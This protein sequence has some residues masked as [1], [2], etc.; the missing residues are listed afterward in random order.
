M[1]QKCDGPPYYSFAGKNRTHTFKPCV[2][3]SLGPKLFPSPF[4]TTLDLHN[5]MNIVNGLVIFHVLHLSDALL[6]GL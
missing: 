4:R 3:I 6:H 1:R 5:M 2:R